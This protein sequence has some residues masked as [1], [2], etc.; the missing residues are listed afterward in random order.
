MY[1]IVDTT[2]NDFNQIFGYI[3]VH[4][5]A[6]R[7]EN[8]NVNWVRPQGVSPISDVKPVT[9][10]SLAEFEGGNELINQSK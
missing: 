9:G 1:H 3:S 5:I 6:S 10:P 7:I 4:T 2:E 8:N